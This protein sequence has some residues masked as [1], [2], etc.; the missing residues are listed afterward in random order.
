MR[1]GKNLL[2]CAAPMLE[3]VRADVGFITYDYINSRTIRNTVKRAGL[4]EQVEPVDREKLCRSGLEEN[5]S[6]RWF[7]KAE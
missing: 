5:K 3:G 4:I 1:H 2:T 7:N 6:C